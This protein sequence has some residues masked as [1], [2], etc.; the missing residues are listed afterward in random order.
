[1]VNLNRRSVATVCA[2]AMLVAVMAASVSA[3]G[4]AK[5]TTYLTFSGPFALP[6]VSLPAGTYVFE[7]VDVTAPNLVR[8]M[9]RDRSE[10]YLTAFTHIVPRPKALHPD[11]Q[12]S[13]REVP[14]G[15]T[16]PVTVWYPIGDVIGHQFIYPKNSA[17]LN[18]GPAN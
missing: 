1:M 8:V 10:V 18:G 4:T 7:R 5:R 6:G 15:I 2:A 14:R 16:P 13:F 12:V 9:S 3:W 11:R 17:Q